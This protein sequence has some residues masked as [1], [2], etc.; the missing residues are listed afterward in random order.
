MPKPDSRKVVDLQ[1]LFCTLHFRFLHLAGTGVQVACFSRCCS[2]FSNSFVLFLQVEIASLTNILSLSLSLFLPFSLSP[3]LFYSL[4]R[5]L[6]SSL[7]LSFFFL[8]LSLSL[9]FFLF[10]SIPL[11]LPSS[12]FVPSSLSPFLSLSFFLSLPLFLC[13][14]PSLFVSLPL[15]LPSLLFAECFRVSNSHDHKQFLLQTGPK[16]SSAWWSQ[17]KKFNCSFVLLLPRLGCGPRRCRQLMTGPSSQPITIAVIFLH[18]RKR[19]WGVLLGFEVV[20]EIRRH[21]WRYIQANFKINCPHCNSFS[22]VRFSC[23]QLAYRRVT[24]TL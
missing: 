18:C 15:S 19:F 10:L 16:M 7:F 14:F 21:D 2:V 13:F 8:S 24:P 9:S 22:V 5:S 6:S 11:S 23:W 12:L 17:C 3:S 20:F 4:F 1:T